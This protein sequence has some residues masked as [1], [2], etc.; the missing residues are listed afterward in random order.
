MLPFT[1]SLIDSGGSAL[2]SLNSPF[3]GFDPLAGT[4]NVGKD[5]PTATYQIIIRGATNVGTI[6]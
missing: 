6:N 2:T 5:T 3:I 1:Y 4:I